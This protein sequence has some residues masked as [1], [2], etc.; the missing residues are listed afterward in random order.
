MGLLSDAIAESVA[1]HAKY[2]APNLRQIVAALQIPT[3]LLAGSEDE[4]FP[5]EMK[6]YPRLI[7]SGKGQ[8]QLISRLS[9]LACCEQPELFVEILWSFWQSHGLV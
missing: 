3:L 9:R 6:E 2:G 8:F 4:I 5:E 1:G 7:E